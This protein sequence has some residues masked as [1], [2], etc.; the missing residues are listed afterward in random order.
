M[1]AMR[2]MKA[3]AA[4]VIVG[5]WAA[6]P[7]LAQF[8]PPVTGGNPSGTP[9]N[10]SVWNPDVANYVEL[11]TG[12]GD[13]LFAVSPPGQPNRIIILQRNGIARVVENG[14]LLAT[15]FFDIST[16]AINTQLG[17]GGAAQGERHRVI[18]NT[19]LTFRNPVSGGVVGQAAGTVLTGDRNSEQGLLGIAFPPGYSNPAAT[20]EFNRFY[21]YYITPRTNAWFNVT[22]TPTRRGNSGQT[23]VARMFTDPSNPNRAAQSAVV[24]SIAGSAEAAN[25]VPS[26]TAVLPTE[27]RIITFPQPF[28]NHN[29]GCMVF[30]PDGFLYIGTGDGGSGDDPNNDA[31]E[32]RGNQDGSWLGKLLRVNVNTPTGYS[33]PASNPFVGLNTNQTGTSTAIRPEIFSF[34]IRNPW[35]FSFDRLTG[36]MYMGDVGQNL[37]E[38]INF[39]PAPAVGSGWNYGW[40]ARE[41]LVANQSFANLSIALNPPF[42]NFLNVGAFPSWAPVNPIYTYGHN[43]S[44]TGGF[45]VTGGYV[46]RGR[47]IPSW[48]GR[49]FF[50]DFV[51]NRIWSVRVINGA[52]TDLRVHTGQITGPNLALQQIASFAEDADG[53]MLIVQLNGS[54]RRVVGQ[55]PTVP[56]IN[57]AD[58]A[59]TAGDPGDDGQVNNGDFSLFFSAFFS[60]DPLLNW[61]ADI[62]QTDGTPG[63]DG[64]IDNGD[65]S[66][67][68]SSFFAL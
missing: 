5:S 45:S 61:P 3:A 34:G 68:F 4:T 19:S 14:V 24:G 8:V 15:P 17:W 7:A 55:N 18:P 53:E 62:A 22:G 21:V 25:G 31:L 23:V 20:N 9:L 28:V 67:F 16:T 29:G 48:R 39:A 30:G 52:A 32:L 54:V 6:G 36:D 65:F 1:S 41:G 59:N 50:A 57:P 47:Q 27:E 11:A 46:Y 63:P 13:A 2:A 44:T 35:R 56:A 38:E 64:N 40:R 33:V 51:S 37:W 10:P 42:S 43:N 49:Y 66:L 58:I 26:V 60:T 12:L